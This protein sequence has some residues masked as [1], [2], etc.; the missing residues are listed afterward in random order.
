[1]KKLYLE[2]EITSVCYRTY[3]GNLKANTY[4]FT[5]GRLPKMKTEFM[6]FLRVILI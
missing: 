5:E 1:M 6:E 4:L 2:P 3:G